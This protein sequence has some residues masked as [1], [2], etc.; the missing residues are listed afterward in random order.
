VDELIIQLAAE[1]S[2]AAA[3][4]ESLRTLREEAAA[5]TR[6]LE[7]PNAVFE[8]IDFFMGFINGGLEAI[9]QVAA[10]LPAGGQRAQVDALRQLASNSALEQRRLVMFRDKWVN[11][12][13]AY[14]QMRP[15]LTGVSNVTREQLDA[16]RGLMA[17]AATLET[18][19]AQRDDKDGK[20]FDRR[21]LF[22][23]LFKP[24]K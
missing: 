15:M 4:I 19:L 23:R 9:G 24:D 14:E 20:A 6:L 13:L 22:T 7:G 8:Q 21:A 2:R 11:K 10:E 16:F 17:M 3:A 5:N 18:E 12:P 1:Q